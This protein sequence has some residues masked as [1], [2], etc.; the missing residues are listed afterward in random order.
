MKRHLAFILF[1]L[2]H[3][4]AF[5]QS[6]Q[7]AVKMESYQNTDTTIYKVVEKQPEFFGGL[8]C[9]FQY[10]MS[11][12]VRPE[13][14]VE[15]KLSGTVY[16]TFVIEKDGSTS[17]I[18]VL[19][20]IAGSMA[21]EEA[22]MNFVRTM[23]EWVPAEQNGKRVRAQYTLPLKFR[24]HEE[25]PKDSVLANGKILHYYIPTDSNTVFTVVQQ[26]TEFRG[27]EA[28]LIKYI[29]ENLKY[30]AKAKK[31][32]RRG[33]CYVTF[34]VERDGRLTY[35]YI[36]RSAGEDLDEEALRLVRAMPLWIPGRQNGHTVRLAFN[37]PIRFSE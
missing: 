8:V 5:S 26:P 18:K 17:N 24:P 9:L 31:E 19:R 10:I 3:V 21:F 25:I 1:A 20:G 37:L 34:I 16:L 29:K 12:L 14:E 4:I 15:D 7:P 35:P 32:G 23:P 6:T 33:T 11:E 36:L 30:P 2:P 28:V 22:A 27:G 13:G